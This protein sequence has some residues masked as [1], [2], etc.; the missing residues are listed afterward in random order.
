MHVRAAS[1]RV[2]YWALLAGAVAFGVNLIGITGPVPWRDEAATWI[3]NQRSVSALWAMLGRIDAVH[4][5]YYFGVRAWS[6]VFGS[7]ILSLRI[8]SALAIAVAAALVTLLAASLK[9]PRLAPWAGLIFAILPQ[10]TWAGIEARSYA[11]STAVG[12]AAVLAFWEASRRNTVRLWV[13]YALL[14]ALSV[15]LFLYVA[16]VYLAVAL[17]TF[18][19]PRGIRL[20]AVLASGTAALLSVPIVQLSFA[21]TDQ[22]SWLEGYEITPLRVLQSAFWGTGWTAYIGSAL[23]LASVISA[24]LR[25][26]AAEDR[27]LVA[28]LLGW[29]ILP[30]AALIGLTV[31]LR[32]TYV[33][34]YVTASA[35]ALALLLGLMI[36]RLRPGWQR[37]TVAALTAAVCVPPFVASRQPEAHLTASA[38]VAVLAER[39]RPGDRV[40]VVGQ[41]R[42]ALWW[43]FP[44]QLSEL[45]NISH[46][47][48]DAWKRRTLK[49]PSRPIDDIRG[50][51]TGAGRVWVFADKGEFKD[52]LE[53]LERMGFTPTDRIDVTTGYPVSL[54][55][56]ERRK[57]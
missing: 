12:T 35:P 6:R 51:L 16:L 27:A 10:A 20:R 44:T 28:L 7:S 56:M 26:R 34:R 41:D 8:S 46:Q 32:P 53:D 5:L 17:A 31:F 4:G 21:Q 39:S 36:L 15:Y 14:A 24:V 49:E 57:A 1:L 11:V 38:A 13:A 30:T 45:T 3:A 29:L 48:G 9:G 40:Y 43:A 37:W 18:W 50:R 23:L 25:C 42:H 55:L 47:R 22:I 19:L 2:R 52:S 33:E 54:V